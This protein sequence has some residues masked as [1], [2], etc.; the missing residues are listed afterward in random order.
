MHLEPGLLLLPYNNRWTGK[1]ATHKVALSTVLLGI[2]LAPFPPAVAVTT[3]LLAGA[4]ACLGAKIRLH[5]W[6]ELLA[7]PLLFAAAGGMVTAFSSAEGLWAA[8]TTIARV[9][10]AS[11]A[12]LLLGT[13]TPLLDLVALLQRRCGF[14][15]IAELFVLSYRAAVAVATA[16]MAMV[17][18]ARLRGLGQSWH[19]APLVYGSIAGALAVRS[20]QNAQQAEAGLAVRGFQMGLPLIGPGE[21][22]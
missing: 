21:R 17:T 20:L 7:A 9:F 14:R 5:T 11:S 19:S 15:T 2:A 18:A 16:G 1:K 12:T 10:G 22:P 4:L 3:G 8:L 13:T 6:L